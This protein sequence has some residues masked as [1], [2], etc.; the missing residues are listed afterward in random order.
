[1]YDAVFYF[2]RIKMH[3]SAH[4]IAKFF[5]EYFPGIQICIKF[6]ENNQNND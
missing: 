6:I 5:E 2:G 3:S 1:M 4:S